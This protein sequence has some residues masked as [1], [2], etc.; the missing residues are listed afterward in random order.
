MEG[1]LNQKLE[2]ESYPR[3]SQQEKTDPEQL[4][5]EKKKGPIQKDRLKGEVIKILQKIDL[6]RQLICYNYIN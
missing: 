4:R 1:D 6:L 5:R 2:G 3:L